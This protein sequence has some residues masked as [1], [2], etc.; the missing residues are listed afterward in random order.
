MVD[1]AAGEALGLDRAGHPLDEAANRL[2]ASR[3][4]AEDGRIGPGRVA[5]ARTGQHDLT[6]FGHQGGFGAGGLEE[7]VAGQGDHVAVAQGH[8]VGH[9]GRARQ[10][11]HFADGIAGLDDADKLGPASVVVAENAQSP[12][13]QQIEGVGGIPR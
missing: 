8:D 9:V 7:G 12:G 11:G 4:E 2:G 5:V 6:Q 1:D 10:H 3:D 13:A